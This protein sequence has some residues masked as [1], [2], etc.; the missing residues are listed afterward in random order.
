M[1]KTVSVLLAVLM[2]FVMGACTSGGAAG[3]SSSAAGTYK[4]KSI[5]MAGQTLDAE[6]LVT[7]AGFD[8]NDFK[9]ELKE[10]GEFTVTMLA[11]ETSETVSGTW[12]ADGN[13]VSLTA[14][15]YTE[16][17]SLDGNQLTISSEGT[18]IVFEK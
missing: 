9:I 12:S 14:D 6:A 17:A 10:G 11:G 2:I 16:E 18:D 5:T 3:D 8:I 1:K 15:D 4:M 7:A 13:K